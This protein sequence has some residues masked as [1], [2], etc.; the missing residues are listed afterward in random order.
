L[1]DARFGAGAEVN[2]ARVRQC[3]PCHVVELM[4]LVGSSA[5]NPAR[6]VVRL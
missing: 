1:L 6:R 2:I 5:T 4:P 3:F